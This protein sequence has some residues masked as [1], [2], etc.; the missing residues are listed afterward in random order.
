MIESV[1]IVV[2]LSI[3]SNFIYSV[4]LSRVA[5]ISVIATPLCFH[6]SESRVLRI[7]ERIVCNKLVASVA[8]RMNPLQFSYKART[9]IVSQ[10]IFFS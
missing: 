6:R 1:S 5:R 4:R 10:N 9:K 2:C 3:S 7:M 8:D